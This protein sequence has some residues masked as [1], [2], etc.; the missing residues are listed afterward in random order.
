[1]RSPITI[2]A[3]IAGLAVPA[4]AAQ[5]QT[6]DWTGFSIGARG[7]YTSA[8]RGNDERIL[9]DT[10]LDGTF[11]DTVR[12][13]AGADAFSPGFCGGAA[14]DRTPGAG[15]RKDKGGGDFAV[16]A[17]YDQQFG[18][19]LV[20]VIGEV[21][22]STARD[23]V[24]AFSITPAFYTMT[25]RLRTNGAIRARVGLPIGNTLPYVTAGVAMARV[26][27]SFS[28]S[29]TVNTFTQRDDDTV[30]GLRAGGGI[31]QRFG[32]FSVGALYLYTDYKDSDT[33]V[34]TSGPAPVTNPFILV[35]PAGTDFARSNGRFKTHSISATVSYRL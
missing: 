7:G 32:N 25:R 16:T 33:R 9:F 8:E 26:R 27:N 29:N 11:G 15:C 19:L 28:T 18:N 30:T 2:A 22:T 24:A 14:N 12:T 31:E 20:G 17:G 13:G 21:G 6:A 4:A 34:R 23:S 35:N 5:A 3:A 10:N 1:M